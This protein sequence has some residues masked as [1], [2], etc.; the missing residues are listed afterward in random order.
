MVEQLN[1]TKDMV[2]YLKN[3]AKKIEAIILDEAGTVELV[4]GEEQI[5]MSCL[6]MS[7][8]DYIKERNKNAR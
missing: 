4:H 8:S 7:I 5:G 3:R 2:E 6:G 1:N